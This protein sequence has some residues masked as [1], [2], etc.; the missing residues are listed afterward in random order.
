MSELRQLAALVV[1]ALLLGAVGLLVI[2]AVV[3]S[4]TQEGDIT[5]ERYTAVLYMNGTLTEEYLYNIKVS[6]EYRMLYRSWEAP[7]S[8]QQM[9]IPFIQPLKIEGPPGAATYIR[10]DNGSV[11]VAPPYD[12]DQSVISTILS[13]AEFNEVGVY[14]PSMF[15]AGEYTVRYTFQVH[16]PI[17]YD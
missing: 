6:G 3:A 14:N 8:L 12:N 10:D 2:D 13:L 9:S 7:V 5:V 17:E 15:A 1:V 4:A 11:F 16:P